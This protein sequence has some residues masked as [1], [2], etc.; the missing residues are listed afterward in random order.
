M[1][2]RLQKRIYQHANCHILS[3]QY[4]SLVRNTLKALKML[5]SIYNIVYLLHY[6]Q[7]KKQRVVFPIRFTYYLPFEIYPVSITTSTNAIPFFF[8]FP[9]KEHYGIKSFYALM[10]LDEENVQQ[11]ICRHQ[12]FFSNDCHEV[13]TSSLNNR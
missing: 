8:L 6:T 4:C 11:I 13:L 10:E 7:T 5:W 3:P 12:L 9:L 1:G 2:F